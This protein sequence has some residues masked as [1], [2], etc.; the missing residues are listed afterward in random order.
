V[1]SC[2]FLPVSSNE[3]A[4]IEMVERAI[5]NDSSQEWA[6]VGDMFKDSEGVR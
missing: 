3:P 2:L 1:E 6:M 4:K 5:G